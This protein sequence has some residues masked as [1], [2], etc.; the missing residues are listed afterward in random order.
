MNGHRAVFLDRDGVLNRVVERDGK[1]ASPRSLGDFEIVPGAAQAVRIIREKCRALVIVVTNQPDIERGKLDPKDLERMHDR[2]RRE[3]PLDDLLVC[4]HGTDRCSCR[5]PKPGLLLE[6]AARWG[7]DLADSFMVGDSEK[8]IGAGRNAG[9]RTVVI[10]TSY[11]A[12]TTA[13]GTR[14]GLRKWLS[15]P[16]AQTTTADH[17]AADLMQAVEAMMAQWEKKS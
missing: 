3:V 17:E 1:F 4:P 10:R 8:D 14:S 6:A 9:C 15:A 12:Q 13:E 16:C 5:K 11:N 7:I 2:L